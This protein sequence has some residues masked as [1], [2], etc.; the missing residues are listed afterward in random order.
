MK[1]ETA[2]MT[3]YAAAFDQFKKDMDLWMKWHKQCANTT[4]FPWTEA[5][6]LGTEFESK[7]NVSLPST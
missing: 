7:I 1:T 4:N 3:L 2:V 6:R 5:L